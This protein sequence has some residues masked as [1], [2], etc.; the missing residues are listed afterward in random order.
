MGSSGIPRA[1]LR[2]APPRLI[3]SHA[4]L[5]CAIRPAP[6]GIIAR[7]QSSF[8][9]RLLRSPYLYVALGLGVLGLIAG[10]L[11]ANWL[12]NHDDRVRF[13][14]QEY[15]SQFQDFVDPQA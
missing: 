7:M 6:A 8:P 12:Y 13:R 2:E 5:R 11:I 9:R 3:F 10:L 1:N 4:P 15:W 14:V